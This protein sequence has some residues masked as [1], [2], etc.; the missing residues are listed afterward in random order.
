[1]HYSPHQLAYFA[2]K[3]TLK[4]PADSME[5]MAGATTCGQAFLPRASVDAWAL[6]ANAGDEPV[7]LA[8]GKTNDA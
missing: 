7:L 1:M 2:T 3:L 8:W 6:Y 5:R 4:A